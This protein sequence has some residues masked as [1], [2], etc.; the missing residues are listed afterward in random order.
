MD[1]KI[2]AKWRGGLED[3]LGYE[4]FHW[5]KR[6]VAMAQFVS[7]EDQ[8]VMDLG[9]GSMHLRGL[10]NSNVTYFPVDYKKNAEDTVVCD[11][12]KYEFPEINVDVIVAAGILV[13]MK[14]PLWFLDKI[15]SSCK[16]CIISHKGQELFPNNMLYSQ[17]IIDH[18]K[19]RGFSLTGR[20]IT[21]NEKW[22]L[23]AC[24]E[25]MLPEKLGKQLECTGCGACANVCPKNA[26]E[27]QPDNNGFLRPFCN[28]ERCIECG[29]C[30]KKCQVLDT[31]LQTDHYFEK[32]SEIYA[33]WTRD[34][35]RMN[36]EK[37]TKKFN[38]V[39]DR[40]LLNK[41]DI[42]LVCMM[43]QSI[44]SNLSNYALYQYLKDLGYSVLMIDI[45]PF[46]FADKFQD[47]K[48]A[49][50]YYL[51]NPY[52]DYDF[53]QAKNKWELSEKADVCDMYIAGSDQLW[54]DKFI[55][56]RD[57]FTILDWVPSYK[58]KISY[59][60][61]MR[62]GACENDDQNIAD[63][64][65]LLKRFN[66]ISVREASV[67]S[68]LTDAFEISSVVVLDP[69][70]LCDRSHYDRFARIGRLRTLTERYVAAY[71]LDISSEKERLAQMTANYLTDGRY[72]AMTEPVYKDLAENDL[73]YT[74][75]PGI[76]EWVAMIKNS[77][78]VITDSFHGMCIALIYE[79]QFFVICDQNNKKERNRFGYFL[80]VLEL[81]SRLISS[82]V[83]FSEKS[84][85]HKIDYEKV[86]SRLEQ[87]R[88]DS[89]KWLS[90]ALSARHMFRG[91][92]NEYDFTF[93]LKKEL[94]RIKSDLFI[95]KHCNR[96]I[97]KKQVEEY[98][99]MIVV[100]WGAGNC[101]R[102][103]IAKVCEY[104]NMKYVCDSNPDFWG[105]R[106]EGDVI[107]ISPA[108]LLKLEN[109]LVII[110][111]ENA[112]VAISISNELLN[113]GISNYDHI[114]NW[115]KYIEG[116]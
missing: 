68:Y 49:L 56:C 29:Q 103:N 36:T 38:E 116:K 46:I 96:E 35:I 98:R 27:M 89:K 113:M 58:Y 72:M 48:G 44:D 31:S 65:Y 54:G 2:P 90:N 67:Q 112:A 87:L 19:Q 14:D 4:L 3:I 5:K 71:F 41:H 75:E 20:D 26:I 23:I 9:A 64:G 61:S 82:T 115:M 111:V 39:V 79:K 7:E 34:S 84:W 109:V 18:M 110:M 6:L 91:T 74:V 40:A 59:G 55:K 66:G 21:L 45:P 106:L 30:M 28:T 13:Y 93:E 63:L 43:N 114:Y 100:G 80:S 85:N 42:G 52:K 37:A 10:L 95:Q 76:E 25:K 88:N 86:N 15:A 83:E 99:D 101:F 81:D 11:F 105:Q 51:K 24:F 1:E 16:K 108:E 69:M 50:Y 92:M 78:Y 33:T 17:E 32:E 77:E 60:I 102:N 22:T 70:F 107:C 47:S 104:Y 73:Q 53:L 97:I 62:I 12:N 57:C 94:R 8:S